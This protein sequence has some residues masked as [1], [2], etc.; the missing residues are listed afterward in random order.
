[1]SWDN[2]QRALCA[3]LE[4]AYEP[5]AAADKV[6]I[7]LSTL[8]LQPINGLRHLPE[9]GTC[10]WYIWGGTELSQSADFFQPLHVAHLEQTCPDVLPYLA[11]PPGHRFLIAPGYDDVWEDQ[12]LVEP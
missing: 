6:G 1:M 5:P 12:S 2:D 8:H 4:V 11:L 3:R 7:A 9:N 10:G